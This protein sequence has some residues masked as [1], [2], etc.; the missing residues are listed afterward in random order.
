[1]ISMSTLLE[2]SEQ[3]ERG[4]NDASN[5]PRT[6]PDSQNEPDNVP[7]SRSS[8]GTPRRRRSPSTPTSSPVASTDSSSDDYS[9]Y[10]DIDNSYDVSCWNST[11]C[12]ILLFRKSKARTISA[13][14]WATMIFF[15]AMFAM[16]I[17]ISSSDDTKF[18]GKN[19]AIILLI[20]CFT[21]LGFQFFLYVC[22]KKCVDQQNSN[23]S[24]SEG[25]PTYKHLQKLKKKGKLEERYPINK[26]SA[27]QVE[28]VNEVGSVNN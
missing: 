21:T 3:L 19:R 20:N 16:P 13:L 1:M 9:Q 5:Y 25:L 14:T 23:H 8:N 17:I 4:E 24:D 2:R 7:E 28:I 26:V 22:T 27:S 18:F 15:L 12:K 10:S 6:V 11:F